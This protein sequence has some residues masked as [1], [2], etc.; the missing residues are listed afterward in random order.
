MFQP[1]DGLRLHQC[2]FQTHNDNYTEKRPGCNTRKST[3]SFSC[4][5]VLMEQKHPPGHETGCNFPP[6]NKTPLLKHLESVPEG[7][8]SIRARWLRFQSVVAA[9]GAKIKEIRKKKQQHVT[10]KMLE[11][12]TVYTAVK[13]EK[14]HRPLPSPKY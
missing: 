14:R 12:Q 10:I 9:H 1:D 11:R 4:C 5:R 7:N 8:T 2:C 3:F 6:V 13:K